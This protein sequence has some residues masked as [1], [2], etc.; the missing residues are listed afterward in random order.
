LIRSGLAEDGTTGDEAK[1]DGPGPASADI[2]YGFLNGRAQSVIAGTNR[3]LVEVPIVGKENQPRGH[4][5]YDFL[6]SICGMWRKLEKMSKP[7]ALSQ[8]QCTLY[9]SVTPHLPLKPS[10]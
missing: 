2:M 9:S 1:D 4:C 8:Q 10:S 3:K 5:L 7:M 6:K